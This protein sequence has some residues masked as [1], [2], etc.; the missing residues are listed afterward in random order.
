MAIRI[1]LDT[2]VLS[3]YCD[4]RVPER[5]S[6]TEEFW[7][8]RKEFELATS[9]VARDELMRVRNQTLKE[10]F[11]GLLAELKI[12]LVT[13]EMRILADRYVDSA[14]FGPASFNDALHVAAAVITRQDILLS[15]N[16]RHLVNR[17]RRAAVNQI[18][19]SAG[20]PAIEILAPPELG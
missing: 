1:Y 11:A 6:A 14:V 9:E 13:E 17:R 3:A 7:Q 20:L 12:H 2:S 16:F 19:V 15:W 5:R 10:E 4:D 8:R 18:N